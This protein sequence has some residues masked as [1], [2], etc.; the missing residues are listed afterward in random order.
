MAV[1]EG[2]RVSEVYLETGAQLAGNIYKGK[3]TQV[4]PGMHAAFVDVGIDRSAYLSLE[5]IQ[6][7]TAFEQDMPS[8]DAESM[9][10][11]TQGQDILVQVI[12]EPRYG[13]GA[14]VTAR[15]SLPGRY[16]VFLGDTEFIGISRRIEQEQERMRLKELALSIRPRGKGLI[17]RTAAEGAEESEIRREVEQLGC[18]WE[19][20]V[21]KEKNA[22]SPSLIFKEQS[23]FFKA[24][25]DLLDKN[26][27]EICIEGQVLF[28]QVRDFL[29]QEAYLLFKEKV[30]LIDSEQNLFE[31][32]GVEK[33]I[34]DA[35]RPR[36][37]LRSGG[38]L[39]FDHTEGLTVID[40]NTGR[41][42][43][44]KN[45]QETVFSTNMEA[46]REIARQIR[47]RNIGGIIVVDFID[48]KQKTYQEE[49]VY[50]LQEQVKFDR[51]I[52]TVYSV[53]E[54]GLVQITR[55]RMGQSLLE[56]L[57]S[58][59]PACKGTGR[60]QQKTEERLKF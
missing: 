8:Q 52:T 4:Y 37:N 1:V 21:E 9:M 17:V 43:G 31:S 34:R 49:I 55:K 15:L 39:V 7:D 24:M 22:P 26:V 50:V 51:M 6:D 29:S 42:V 35:L 60:S 45:V 19:T 23:L 30:F 47:L 5:E 48:M 33:A 54:L 12:R 41:N 18:M 14:R 59:C 3:V 2:N 16:V 53:T 28:E 46:A 32:R 38:Y 13:K 10:R 11:L 20:V 36:V 44:K 56:A 57:T 58:A 40:V 25:R 27:T